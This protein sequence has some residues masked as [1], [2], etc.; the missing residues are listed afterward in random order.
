[1][2]MHK[3]AWI[4][5]PR[6]R[7]ITKFLIVLYAVGMLAATR[8]HTSYWTSNVSL[9]EHAAET[10]PSADILLNLGT[11]YERM[12]KADAAIGTYMQAL[13]ADPLYAASYASLAKAMLDRGDY[14]KALK[15]AQGAIQFDPDNVVALETRAM[16]LRRSGDCAS[17]I[18]MYLRA[19]AVRDS[20]MAH[21]NM[22]ECL[23]ALGYQ[24][25]ALKHF[26]RSMAIEESVAV[27]NNLALYYI[28]RDDFDTALSYLDHAAAEAQDHTFTIHLNYA[29]AW[30]G[31]GRMEKAAEHAL[32]ALQWAARPE[33]E[34]EED[35]ATLD[36]LR[37]IV[38]ETQD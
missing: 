35:E 7:A 8:V 32:Q 26:H 33:H 12:G 36:M 27:Y 6:M 25:L 21:N 22:A 16:A 18:P 38:S 9:F 11:S 31:K 10:S 23:L 37:M 20:A 30:K 3:F 17:A 19:I 4:N 28:F 34:Q 5:T 1:M 2:R 15:F 24:D 29:R 14:E 13:A